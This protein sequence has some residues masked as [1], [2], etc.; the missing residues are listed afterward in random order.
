MSKHP[1]QRIAVGIDGS[2]NS[3]AAV[4]WAIEHARQGDT[5]V[6]VHVWHPYVYGTEL[7]T[8][9]TIDDTA[10]TELLEGEFVRFIPLAKEHEVML[11]RDLIEGD[12]RDTLNIPNID[13]LVIGARGHS[14]IAGILLGSV[15]DYI[16]RHAT[17]PVVV[18]PPESRTTAK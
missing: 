5:I 4:K 10:A 11:K 3:R 7:A 15:A 18:I 2:E 9:F 14:G 13:L 12:A 6:M 1:K 16:T 17:V 8:A